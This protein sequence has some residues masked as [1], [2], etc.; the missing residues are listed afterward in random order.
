MT[1][2][3]RKPSPKPV[4][5]PSSVPGTG[6]RRER[7]IVSAS[8]DRADGM[9]DDEEKRRIAAS[10][11]LGTTETGLRGLMGED[12]E[13]APETDPF[14]GWLIPFHQSGTQYAL[15]CAVDATVAADLVDRYG[16]P[17][18]PEEWIPLG[19]GFVVDVAF[20]EGAHGPWLDSRA[21]LNG[22]SPKISES[23]RENVRR[24]VEMRLASSAFS[25]EHPEDYDE[26]G[27]T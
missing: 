24:E 11:Q 2:A 12:I 22:P 10:E 25:N 20:V 3:R 17:A 18:P 13:E 1:L 5:G 27:P 15:V 14:R 8:L 9:S 16:P 4:G 19:E 7:T 26:E 23:E 6:A 21:V